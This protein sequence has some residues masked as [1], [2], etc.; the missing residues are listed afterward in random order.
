M[1]IT[2]VGVPEVG[3]E[4]VVESVAKVAGRALIG[5]EQC[6]LQRGFA[7]DGSSSKCTSS[8]GLL[9]HSDDHTTRLG[10][11]APRIL[12]AASSAAR[13]SHGRVP[14]RSGCTKESQTT[15]WGAGN[16]RTREPI[17]IMF[18]A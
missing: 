15:D 11:S 5:C 18:G 8:F 3:E 12:G 6:E 16:L 1:K 7:A 4:Q 14:S 2:G 10:S 17:S 9:G 13:L